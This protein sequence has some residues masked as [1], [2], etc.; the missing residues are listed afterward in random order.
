MVVS[1]DVLPLATP[2]LF[3]PILSCIDKGKARVHPLPALHLILLKDKRL[4]FLNPRNPVEV[5]GNLTCLS[6]SENL[7]LCLHRSL[8]VVG[9]QGAAVLILLWT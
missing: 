7:T 6:A 8:Q 1:C 5:L 4:N 2:N 3:N 9:V